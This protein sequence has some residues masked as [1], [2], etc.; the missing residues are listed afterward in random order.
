MTDPTVDLIP[1]EP[2]GDHYV[3]SEDWLAAGLEFPSRVLEHRLLEQGYCR[4]PGRVHFEGRSWAATILLSPQGDDQTFALLV[5]DRPDV[6]DPEEPDIAPATAEE[7]ER[8][9]DETHSR[10]GRAEGVLP[11]QRAE[12]LSAFV[13]PRLAVGDETTPVP[14]GDLRRHNYLLVSGAPGSGKT[15][16]LR[17]WLLWHADKGRL[18]DGDLLPISLS[19]RHYRPEITVEVALRREAESIGAAWLSR[20]LK[21][22]AAKGRLAVAFDGVDELAFEDR[23]LAMS[24][25][26]S[27]TEHYPSCRYLVTTRPEVSV[28]LSVGLK[29]A[30]LLPL[31]R[32]RVR[33]MAYH[34]LYETGSWKTFTC[35]VEAEPALDWVI[36]N[37]LALSFMIARFLR[38]EI[39]PSYVGEI[40]GAVIDLFIDG[41][42]ASRGIVRTRERALSPAEKRK[43]L[44]RISSA[45][46]FDDLQLIGEARKLA[47]ESDLYA[48][49]SEHTG[50]LRHDARWRFRSEVVEEFFRAGVTVSS[51]ASRAS[52]FRT[53]LK[54]PLGSAA[55]HLARFIG[56]MSSDAGDR[57]DDIL[58]SPP[59]DSFP[60]AV[61]LTDVLSQGMTIRPS[62][63]DAYATY[64]A[65]TLDAA[66][67]NT[68]S[69]SAS[70]NGVSSLT[71]TR[72]SSSGLPLEDIV[73]LLHA[74]HRARD[75]VSARTLETVLSGRRSKSLDCISRL[76]HADGELQVTRSDDAATL[77]VVAIMPELSTGPGP[78]PAS[79]THA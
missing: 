1:V 34:R 77:K 25:I 53:L 60:L 35:K 78:D 29:R 11:E 6:D 3:V 49:L 59:A 24:Q 40:V 30:Q 56:F 19:L 42:D 72:R 50:L 66:V 52:E 47:D 13:E 57:I 43:I 64:V 73:L 62:I 69:V 71:V 75:S 27:F 68:F 32:P 14:W 20:D 17:H 4:S 63:L 12:I 15:T 8:F 26:A 16:L 58:K 54:K 41:W 2:Q 79:A 23:A 55:S 22:Y 10:F 5:L 21:A 65:A 44:S 18:A 61:H 31:D 28:D 46:Q 39:A 76:I 9:W 38:R 51:L 74:L 70:E 7:M 37:P 48:M 36:S 67:S 33:Q 45:G